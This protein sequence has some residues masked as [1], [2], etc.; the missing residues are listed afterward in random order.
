MDNALE[1]GQEQTIP[2]LWEDTEEGISFLIEIL[3]FL[4]A[5]AGDF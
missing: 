2:F 4:T 1:S 5:A 3:E